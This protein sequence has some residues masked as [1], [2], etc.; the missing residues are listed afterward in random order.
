MSVFKAVV[1][2]DLRVQAQYQD[3]ESI[4]FCM[5]SEHDEMKKNSVAEASRCL[6]LWLT[7]FDLET[8]YDKGHFTDQGETPPG[9]S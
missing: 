1:W 5:F 3:T 8:A 2:D 4:Y 6:R 9:L 7:Q